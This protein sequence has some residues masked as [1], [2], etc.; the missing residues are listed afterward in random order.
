MTMST[1]YGWTFNGHHYTTC[2]SVRMGRPLV[3]YHRDGVKLTERE[4]R[5]LMAADRAAAARD[6]VA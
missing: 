1:R 2:E 5:R 4:W 6:E 3:S